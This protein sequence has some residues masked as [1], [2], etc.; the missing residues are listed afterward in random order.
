MADGI[1]APAPQTPADN[2]FERLGA[3][4]FAALMARYPIYATF[5][6]LH[7]HDGELGDASREAIISGI[8]ESR[9]FL[10]AVEAIDPASLS[11]F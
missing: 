6:G 2:Q 10:A 8:D 1:A 11:P 5:L 9:S 7:E 3:E 4:R